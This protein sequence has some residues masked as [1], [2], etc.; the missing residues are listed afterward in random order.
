MIENDIVV[1]V[2]NSITFPKDVDND[3]Y[4][5]TIGKKYNIYRTFADHITIIGDN[6]LPAKYSKHRFK[7]LSKVREEKLNKIINNK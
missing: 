6:G 2:D 7:L 3:L 5:I 1:C 4:S